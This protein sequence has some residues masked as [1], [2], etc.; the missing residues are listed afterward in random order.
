MA[1]RNWKTGEESNNA[2]FILTKPRV[3]L[4]PVQRRLPQLPININWARLLFYRFCS[5]SECAMSRKKIILMRMRILHCL[6]NISYTLS[7]NWHIKRKLY[8]P[9]F[10]SKLIDWKWKGRLRLGVDTE[11]F[12]IK[13]QEAGFLEILKCLIKIRI[14]FVHLALIAGLMKRFSFNRL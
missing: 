14:L 3:L 9:N 6:H 2:V 8:I 13:K 12:W 11:D 7:P 10:L 5:D 4:R 1:F